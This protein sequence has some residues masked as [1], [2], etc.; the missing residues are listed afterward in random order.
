MNESK[1][2]NRGSKSDFLIESVKEQRVDGS[3]C[4][5]PKL[6]HLR[7]TLMGFERNYQVKIP[8]K[9]LNKHYYSTINY[10]STINPWFITGLID[11]VKI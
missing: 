10:S 5:K 1:M 4:I 3:W 8:S 7:Y 2:G 9:Q 6:M 11:A